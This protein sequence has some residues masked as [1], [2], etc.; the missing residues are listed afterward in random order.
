MRHVLLASIAPGGVIGFVGYPNV[1]KSSV[2][3]ALFGAK[4]VSMSR[5][6]GKTKHLQT[7]ELTGGLSLCD[8]PGLVFP[9]VVATKAHLAIN[10]TAPLQELRDCVA[11]V[12]L[13]VQKLGAPAVLERCSGRRLRRDHRSVR[14]RAAQK[15]SSPPG[16]PRWPWQGSTAACARPA[17]SPSSTGER[18]GGGHIS[19]PA[20]RG[21]PIGRL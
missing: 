13:V 2:I 3:N 7:L 15:A 10:G 18:R 12:R 4:K 20:R 16:S 6:P 19:P 8:C 21:G 9:S 11:P 5:T 14:L 1:G 17:A